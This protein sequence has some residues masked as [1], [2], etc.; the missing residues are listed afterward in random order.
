MKKL[1]FVMLAFVAFA[2]TACNDNNEKNE[3]FVSK[4]QKN[5]NV[6]LEEFTG[7][8]CGY[9]PDGQ[10]RAN[11]IL[12]QNKGRFFPINIH[13]GYLS[14]AE[15]QCDAAKEIQGYYN[16]TGV[17]TGLINRGVGKL[18]RGVWASATAQVLAEP[19]YVN[20]AA[21]GT[22]ERATRTLN[23]KVQAYYLENSDEATNYLSVAMVQNN[24][25]ADQSNGQ[26]NPGQYIS[27]TGKYNHMHILRG[28]VTPTW[29]DAITTTTATS[30]F[31]KEYTYTIPEKLGTHDIVLDDVIVLAF[32]CEDQKYNVLNA[33]EAEITK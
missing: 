3:V 7:Q 18:N 14:R 31:E 15:M 29:G 30:L 19:A 23:L 6:V 26:T 27:A 9:C 2:F 16:I 4:E 12:E 17:P 33:C 13:G 8:G 22:I 32:A 11:Q 21:K 28:M 25:V 24:I 20:V 5:K 1:L 10:L